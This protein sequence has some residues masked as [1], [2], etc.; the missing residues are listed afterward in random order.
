MTQRSRVALA[1][2]GGTITMSSDDGHD[3]TPTLNANDLTAP[4]TQWITDVDIESATLQNVGSP[5]LTVMDALHTLEYAH[6]AVTNGA[7]GVVVVQEPTPSK[8]Q[9]TSSTSCGTGANPSSAPAPCVPPTKREPRA[10]GT[11]SP[12]S[13]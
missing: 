13:A 9:P 1:S 11:W 5:Q 2:L 7:A 8:K 6:A 12:Q 10:P 4:L 3:V